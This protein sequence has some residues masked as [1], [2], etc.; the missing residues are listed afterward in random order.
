[1]NTVTTTFNL[2]DSIAQPLGKGTYERVGGIIRDTQTK[3]VVC[4]L[5][6]TNA[7]TL[8]SFNPVTPVLG[9]LNLGVSTLTLA[10]SISG[11]H[12]INKRLDKIEN[13]LQYIKKTLWKNH[14][15]LVKKIEFS[16]YTNFKAALILANNAFTMSN[17]ENCK[18]SA[19]QAINRFLEAEEYYSAYLDED[20]HSQGRVI[21]EY[22]ETLTLAYLAEIRCYLKLEEIPT[23]Y[24]R[25][26]E[27]EKL[28]KSKFQEYIKILLTSN[29]A[30]YLH[31]DLKEQISL[32][33]LTNIY[34]WFNNSI[35][36]NYVYEKLR[37]DLFK[38][39]YKPEDWKNSL[40]Q[41]VWKHIIYEGYPR[42]FLQLTKLME[43]IEFIIETHRRIIGYHMELETMMHL[44]ISFA[45]WNNLIREEKIKSEN[46]QLMYII[47][48]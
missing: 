9:L 32:T 38:I 46:V 43:K 22:L 48:G 24:S 37:Q 3:Q 11:F 12:R 4:W 40:P 44:N 13:D 26:Q 7:D 10:V 21:D 17:I 15:E 27:A 42:T 39:A 14:Q 2:P 30:A 23:A 36:E 1:M 33:R 45:E 41:A 47:P 18:A 19:M 35:D 6:E 31:P 29:P 20:L 28:L 34:R 16:H 25:L 5:R 8:L